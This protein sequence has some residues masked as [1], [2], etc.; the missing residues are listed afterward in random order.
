[1]TRMKNLTIL[2]ARLAIIEMNVSVLDS[3][4]VTTYK[5]LYVVILV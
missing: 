2:K 3:T 1:M 5:I 4:I